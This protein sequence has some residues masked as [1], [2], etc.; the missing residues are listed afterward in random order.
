MICKMLTYGWRLVNLWSAYYL[1]YFYLWYSFICGIPLPVILFVVFF[2]L[3]YYLS[4]FLPV[5][6]LYLWYSFTC[7]I[8]CRIP[9]P[10][11]SFFVFFT[12]DILRTLT[13]TGSGLTHLFHHHTSPQLWLLTVF[14][15]R[16]DLWGKYYV[17]SRQTPIVEIGGT[18]ETVE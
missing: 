8:I 12:C 5:I 16:V 14:H 7:S 4:Y 13:T 18:S 17:I 10:V 6:F 1:S 9:L 15:A 11:V 3:W 2:Y